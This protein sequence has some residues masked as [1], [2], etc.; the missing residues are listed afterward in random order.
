M[1]NKEKF[2]FI[3]L[4]FTILIVIIFICIITLCAISFAKKENKRTNY[5]ELTYCVEDFYICYDDDN[6][7]YEI[8][9]KDK[10][11]TIRESQLDIKYD[12]VTY[13]VIS[14]NNYDWRYNKAILFIGIGE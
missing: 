6:Y 3:K 1:A 14:D 4:L 5:H 10:T 2:L 8:F 11:Y 9:T 7:C 12:D 13:I